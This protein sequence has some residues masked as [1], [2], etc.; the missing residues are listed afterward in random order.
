M[1]PI[2]VGSLPQEV[3]R[4]F[5]GGGG[6]GAVCLTRATASTDLLEFGASL[7]KKDLQ[8]DRSK[9]YPL[10]KHMRSETTVAHGRYLQNGCKLVDAAHVL[11]HLLAQNILQSPDRPPDSTQALSARTPNTLDSF[12]YAL[13]P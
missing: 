9:L 10:M 1:I 11:P 8:E 3:G 2:F 6:G 7:C 5:G 13:K 4:K 12:V